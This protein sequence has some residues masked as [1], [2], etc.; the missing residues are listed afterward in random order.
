MITIHLH[1][2]TFFAYHGF[3]PEEQKLGNHFIVDVEV[4]FVPAQHFDDELVNTVNY[5]ILY[6]IAAQQMKQ[7]AKLLETV[8][9]GISDEI[10]GNYPD[11]E[12]IRVT[13]RKLNPQLGGKVDYT[14]ITINYDKA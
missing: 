13:V 2:A 8:A 4:S 3:Y 9:Q 14:G 5:E 12:N 1:G 11:L 7:T 6:N 10:K